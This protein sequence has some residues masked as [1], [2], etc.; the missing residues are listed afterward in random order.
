M[1]EKGGTEKKVDGNRIVE[2][3]GEGMRNGE[4][5]EDRGGR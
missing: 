5:D 3:R 4:G 2:K 1:T